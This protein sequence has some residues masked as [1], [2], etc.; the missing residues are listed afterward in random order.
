MT[1]HTPVPAAPVLTTERLT[2][3]PLLPTDVDE[4][5]AALQDPGI[6]R[7]ID[8]P[9]PYP[10]SAA[11]EW[12]LNSSPAGWADGSEWNVTIRRTEDGVLV[13]AIGVS[14]HSEFRH[15]VGYWTVAGHRG[16]GHMRAALDAVA[17]WAFTEGG[18]VRLI[19]RADVDNTGSRILAEKVG[20]RLEGVRRAGMEHR[21]VLRDCHA[22][23]LLPEDLGLP[24]RLPRDTTPKS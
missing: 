10:R 18:V 17:R 7:W 13:G 20:F 3:R 24:S 19:W 9:V 1:T 4:L 23:A 2:L 15:E 16:Q 11:E 12:A 6:Q 8:V 14:R 22:A 5:H 21:G